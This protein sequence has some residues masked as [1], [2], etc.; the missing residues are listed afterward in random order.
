MSGGGTSPD[1][2]V[3]PRRDV[4]ESLSR[5]VGATYDAAVD[6]LRYEALLKCWEAFLEARA[7]HARTD[8]DE[9]LDRFG[10]NADPEAAARK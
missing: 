6:P 3:D 1:E 5:L 7:D 10:R 9:S 4:T 8:L 2:A